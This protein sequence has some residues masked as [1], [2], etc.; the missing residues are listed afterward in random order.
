MATPRLPRKR[1]QPHDPHQRRR[2]PSR[3]HRILHHQP[4]RYWSAPRPR[5]PRLLCPQRPATTPARTLR[6]LQRCRHRA[7][8]TLRRQ[9]RRNPPGRKNPR[10]FPPP[11]HRRRPLGPPVPGL[12]KPHR[13][14]QRHHQGRH[15]PPR[16]PHPLLLLRR[17][18]RHRRDQH[19]QADRLVCRHL[20][21]HDRRPLVPPRLPHLLRPAH[22]PPR[23]PHRHSLLHR[24]VHS[25]GKVR[26][27]DCALRRRPNSA[28]T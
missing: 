4:R 8:K 22:D 1:Q 2:Q 26:R 14:L 23:L 9:T 28:P 17:T 24:R 13:H 21:R 20:R 5:R 27:G 7:A 10:L 15:L 19:L 11:Q 25:L 12:S 3:R 18:P 6:R 16:R